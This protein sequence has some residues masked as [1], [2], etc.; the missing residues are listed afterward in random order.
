MVK[1]RLFL[2]FLPKNRCNPTHMNT[3]RYRDFMISEEFF[4]T[5]I[6]FLFGLVDLFN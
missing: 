6:P 4:F 1:K 2:Q 5:F 3:K